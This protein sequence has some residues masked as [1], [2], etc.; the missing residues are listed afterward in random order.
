[1]R[2]A[3]GS[4]A[5]LALGGA[6]AASHQATDEGL[7][8]DA[9]TPEILREAAAEL[10]PD[11]QW[12]TGDWLVDFVEPEDGEGGS[13]EAIA[14]RVAELDAL[15]DVEVEP[16]G[17]Y[18]EGEHLYRVRADASAWDRIDDGLLA[19]PLVEIVEPEIQLA[20]PHDAVSANA[21]GDPEIAKP[22]RYAVDDPMFA[23]QW[24]ME[25]IH[26]PEAWA[27]ER[28][29]DVIVAV[30]DTG[31]AWKTAKGVKQLPDLA[32]SK[33]T[34]GESFVSGLPEGLD[35]HAH[36]SHVAGT[37]AQKTNN[38]IGVTG[39][40]HEATIMPL[41]VLSADG[42]GSVPG[43]ANA[44]RYAAD[45]GA[46]VINMSLGGPLPSKVLAKA[47]E[48][49]HDKGVTTVCAAGNESR[50]RVGYPA[51]NKYAVAVSATNYERGL[52]FYSNWGKDIDV[53]APGGDTRADRNGDGHPDGVL[54]N[55]IKIQKPLEND[56]LWFQGTSMASPHAAGVA[57]L[58][59]GSGV[60]NPD[61]VER[62]MKETAAHPDGKT[63]DQRFGAGIV[64]AQAAVAKAQGDYAPERGG[65]LALLG[66]LGL[67]GLGIAGLAGRRKLLAAAGLGGTAILASGALGTTPIAY[68]IAGVAGAFGSPLLLSAALPLLATLLLLGWKPARPVLAGLALGYAA[69]L[70]HGAFVLPTLLSGLP[71]GPM[72]D[73][74]WLAANAA[75]SL[76]LAARIS[77]R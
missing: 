16:A 37:I 40:A 42:R 33:F 64:D 10:G 32:G 1:L 63:W 36:G 49:A 76:W 6:L 8:A 14:A 18:S 52:T 7:S 54:Q 23:L 31:V 67:G 11:S 65:L 12:L 46:H 61:E 4:A 55:T 71:G 74:L 39:V 51:A 48:Y 60:T 68:G 20:L 41:K 43:I 29:D 19:D 3:L 30:I 66:L 75:L 21:V 5:V 77:R 53:A 15:P 34:K 27:S 45:N 47:I 50:S 25:Q 28:G 73:R 56:Y 69:L 24:H 57:A 59:V 62:V 70:A 44:I 26:A 38:G 58:V 35:D 22:P 13:E 9:I 17:F 2:L 72:I